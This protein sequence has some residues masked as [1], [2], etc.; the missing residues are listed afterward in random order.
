MRVGLIA[1]LV[2]WL[3]L[4]SLRGTGTPEPSDVIV[5]SVSLA[6]TEAY[7]QPRVFLGPPGVVPLS[8]IQEV[9]TSTAL[10]QVEIRPRRLRIALQGGVPATAL[11]ELYAVLQTMF[12]GDVVPSHELSLLQE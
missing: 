2:G 8:E 11:H 4:Y 6:Q 10:P 7:G 5:L 1:C 3:S 9:A 12:V